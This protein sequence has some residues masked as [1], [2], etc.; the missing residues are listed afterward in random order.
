MPAKATIPYLVSRSS[1]LRMHHLMQKKCKRTNYYRLWQVPFFQLICFRTKSADRLSARLC[2]I[3]SFYRFADF[4]GLASRVHQQVQKQM[5]RIEGIPI[6]KARLIANA[7]KAKA[8]KARK[9]TDCHS[10]INK[11]SPVSSHMQV[12]TKVA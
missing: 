8:T 10:E 1:R 12:R 4:C 9:T 11:K 5:V 2:R 3:E 6:V 7:R